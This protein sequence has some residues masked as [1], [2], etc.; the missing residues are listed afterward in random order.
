MDENRL[1][2]FDNN[3]RS[4]LGLRHLGGLDEAGRGCLAGPVIAACVV[5]KAS[6]PLPGLNDSKQLTPGQRESLIGPILEHAVSWGLGFATNSEIDRINILQATLL[7]S[8]RAMA[9]L[10]PAPE[11]LLTDYLKPKKCRLPF[12]S[13]VK[14]D[15]RSQVIAAASVLAKTARDHIMAS[16]DKIHPEYGFRQHKGYGTRQH[17]EALHLNGPSNL[18]RF[19]FGGVSF[20]DM[21]VETA[22]VNP[23][24]LE[25]SAG[26][27]P[28]WLRIL[29][30]PG[31]RLDP[32]E[33]ESMI[34][35]HQGT[36]RS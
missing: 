3:R 13:L 22:P 33:L 16:L 25:V 21:P 20:F 27:R 30:N 10:D 5:F 17:R 34:P 24:N 8:R 23:D 36:I 7:A 11:F 12:E 2:A 6:A 9:E 19:S 35:I 1:T 15:S 32:A 4:K 28:D 29:Q 18:H 31:E 26:N 14:G